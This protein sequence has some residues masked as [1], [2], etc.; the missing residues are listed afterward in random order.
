MTRRRRNRNVVAWQWTR[1]GDKVLF[2][3][4][5]FVKAFSELIGR[6][7]YKFFE[8]LKIIR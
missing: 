7:A 1:L 2:V 8:A 3:L 4:L 6:Y 5:F